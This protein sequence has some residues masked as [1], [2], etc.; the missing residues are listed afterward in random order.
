MPSTT[1]TPKGYH[2]CELQ[3]FHTISK[4]FQRTV[5]CFESYKSLEI[6][7]FRASQL[8]QKSCTLSKS[9]LKYSPATLGL[10]KLAESRKFTIKAVCSVLF[11]V[12]VRQHSGPLH[13][14]PL[15]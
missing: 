8:F 3:C 10:G 13:R 12:Q 7:H 5:S 1:Y 14:R 9:A 4:Y 15:S 6:K 2:E 11:S